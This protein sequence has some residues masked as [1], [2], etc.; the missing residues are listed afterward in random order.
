MVS[1]WK[2]HRHHERIAEIYKRAGP[3][4]LVPTD[5]RN[6]LRLADGL[7]GQA[8]GIGSGIPRPAARRVR[9]LVSRFRS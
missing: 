9:A 5:Q 3:G 4:C 8:P 6:R 7:A 2:P 1:F